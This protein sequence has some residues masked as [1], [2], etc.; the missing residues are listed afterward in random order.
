M[1]TARS[2]SS[3]VVAMKGGCKRSPVVGLEAYIDSRPRTPRR[4]PISD[5]PE[6]FAV[7]VS[8]CSLPIRQRVGAHR[9]WPG[10]QCVTDNLRG[11]GKFIPHQFETRGTHTGISKPNFHLHQFDEL[12]EIR[13]GV[14]PEQRQEPAIQL[15]GLV[16]F[17]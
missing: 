5:R 7:D 13:D 2:T 8:I 14:H 11:L 9:L 3:G 4:A 10:A 16:A 1:R 17:S 12:N 6:S 15:K